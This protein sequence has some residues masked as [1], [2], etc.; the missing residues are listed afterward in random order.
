MGRK[1]KANANKDGDAGVES[2][3]H[4]EETGTQF[5]QKIEDDIKIKEFDQI[6]VESKSPCLD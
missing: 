6:K 1:S 5:T 2:P 3:A 4:Q